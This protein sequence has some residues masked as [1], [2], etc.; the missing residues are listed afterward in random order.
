MDSYDDRVVETGDMIRIVSNGVTGSLSCLIIIDLS[1]LYAGSCNDRKVAIDV[2]A[3]KDS[4]VEDGLL[5]LRGCFT[6]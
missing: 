5:Q 1:R 2:V 4:S 3:S 6:I